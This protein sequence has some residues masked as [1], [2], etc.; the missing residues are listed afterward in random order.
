VSISERGLQIVISDN[1]TFDSPQIRGQDLKIN[2][3]VA[4]KISVVYIL[5]IVLAMYIPIQT[6]TY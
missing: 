5:S 2:S 6:P 1:P 3:V 4:S